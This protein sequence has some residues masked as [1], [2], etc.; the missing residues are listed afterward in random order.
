VDQLPQAHGANWSSLVQMQ[1]EPKQPGWLVLLERRGSAAAGT[2]RDGG[3][4][5]SLVQL[6]YNAEAAGAVQFIRRRR[7]SRQR[8]PEQ[9]GS[10]AVQC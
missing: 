8:L 6:Q 3:C 7:S 10:V 1:R 5:G 4:R 9:R 2:A